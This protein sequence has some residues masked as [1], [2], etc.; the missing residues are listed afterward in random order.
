MSEGARSDD[1]GSGNFR[2]GVCRTEAGRGSRSVRMVVGEV[3]SEV[4]D[5]W[6]WLLGGGWSIGIY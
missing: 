1:D 4:S 2:R 5:D 3:F 6:S